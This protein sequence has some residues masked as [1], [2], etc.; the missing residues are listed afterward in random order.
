MTTNYNRYFTGDNKIL[1]ERANVIKVPTVIFD[2]DLT[3]AES[4]ICREMC[5]R[6]KKENDWV[7]SH[8]IVYIEDLSKWANMPKRKIMKAITSLIN[9][10]RVIKMGRGFMLV[11]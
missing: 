4:D 9:K 3:R 7:D 8:P 1:I 11:C 2:W 10:K 6:S 5:P